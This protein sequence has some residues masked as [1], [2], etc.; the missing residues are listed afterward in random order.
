MLDLAVVAPAN[1][2]VGH[3]RHKKGDDYQSLHSSTTPFL[4]LAV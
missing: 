2:H 4:M 1:H 3:L